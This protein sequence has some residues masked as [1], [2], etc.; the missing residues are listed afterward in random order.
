MMDIKTVDVEAW[1]AELEGKKIRQA[2]ADPSKQRIRN[3]F[4]MPVCMKASG[5]FAVSDLKKW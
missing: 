4:L 2:L 1:L 5:D 3:V